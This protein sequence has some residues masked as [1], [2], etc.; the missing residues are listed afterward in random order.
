MNIAIVSYSYTG[1]NDALAECIAQ[2]LSAKHFKV[3]AQKPVTT[4]TIMLDM[5]LGRT[6]KVQPD[7][8]TLKPYE[9]VLFVAPVWMGS[10]ASPLRAYFRYLKSS[11][12][13]YGFLSISGGADGENP[14]LHSE[15]VKRTGVSP[16]LILDQHIHDFL[17]PDPKPT[18]KDT[19]AYQISEAETKQLSARAI[20]EINKLTVLG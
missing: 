16:L 5:L 2:D 12:Q 11:P 10:V 9:L 6:P 19:S 13:S 17:P 14:K 1:N 18:R 8:V 20:Q 3:Q 4:G 15:L 7:P